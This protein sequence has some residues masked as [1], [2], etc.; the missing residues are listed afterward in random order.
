MSKSAVQRFFEKYQNHLP[1]VINGVLFQIGWWI[2]MIGHIYIAVAYTLA[3][4]L[5]HTKWLN[6][7]QW[8]ITVRIIVFGWAL[9]SFLS[10]TG[11]INLEG[12]RQVLPLWLLCIW[13]IF[14]TTPFLSLKFLNKHLLLASVLGLVGGGLTYLAGDRLRS[15]ISLGDPG[16]PSW[17]GGLVIGLVW[18][19]F[20]PLLYAYLRYVRV[21]PFNDVQDST[22][23]NIRSDEKPAVKNS[24]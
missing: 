17:Y 15:D 18:S 5:L 9:D 6:K 10:F 20:L 12:D 3:F 19:V 8:L 11:V 1:T 16:D 4:L 21:P 13:V 7:Q 2:C 23:G 22:E 24:N 14:A